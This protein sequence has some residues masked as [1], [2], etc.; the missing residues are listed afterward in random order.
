METVFVEERDLSALLYYT[1]R[2]RPF[3]DL[4]VDAILNNLNRCCWT[5]SPF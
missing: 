4:A 2:R 5:L 1:N 3:S